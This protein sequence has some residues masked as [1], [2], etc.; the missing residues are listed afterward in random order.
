MQRYS[1]LATEQVTGRMRALLERELPDWHWVCESGDDPRE[2]DLARA[3][4]LFGRC[5]PEWLESA[6]RL[7]WVHLAFAGVS[8]SLCEAARDRDLVLTNSSG[9]YN[10]T[11]AEHSLMLM[12]ALAR[13][14]DACIENQRQR[15][16]AT[17]IRPLSQDL[18]GGTVAIVGAGGIGQAIARLCRAFG[19]QVLASR[20]NLQPTPYVDRLYGTDEL[21]EMA[22]Q[23]EWLVITVPLTDRTEGLIDANVL[24]ALPVGARLIN[25][26]RGRVIDETALLAALATGRLAGAGLDVTAMEPTPADSPLWRHPNVLITPH[27]SSIAV[28]A[29][30]AAFE[31]FV[32]NAH[33][34][35][36]G[37]PLENVVDFRLGY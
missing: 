18:A 16:W 37:L 27:V 9:I 32:R 33:S 5:R 6:P 7:R 13:R 23:A 25:V 21:L 12:L 17:P 10:Q 24:D 35:Q 36:A 26:S 3:E 34:F 28:N 22:S 19:M 11:I 14:L 15:Q 8:R 30:G 29:S 20:A 4:V 2:A 31:L 1:L